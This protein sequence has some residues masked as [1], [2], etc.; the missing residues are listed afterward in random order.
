MKQLNSRI[1]DAKGIVGSR[2]EELVINV[3][4]IALVADT[5]I[6]ETS[7]SMILT[8]TTEIALKKK[9]NGYLTKLR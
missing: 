7:S 3:L 8:N 4:L 2:K 1:L 6:P 9:V 5:F